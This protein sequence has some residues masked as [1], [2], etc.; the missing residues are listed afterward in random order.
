MAT[1]FRKELFDSIRPDLKDGKFP[2]VL[3]DGLDNVLDRAGVPRDDGTAVTASAATGAPTTF[4]KELTDLV[5][6]N[7]AT[8]SFS[9]E[10]V[11]AIDALLDRAGCPRDGTAPAGAPPK[12]EPVA[13]LAEVPPGRLDV[14]GL[15]AFLGLPRAGPFDDAAKSALLARLSNPKA[16]GL[17]DADIARAAADLGVS[18][19]HIKAVR[20]VEV[21]KSPFDDHGRPTI[22]YERHVFTRNTVPKGRFNAS[23]PAISGGPYGKGGY[24]LASAQYGKLADACALD[25]EAAF[26]GCSWGAFQVL[27]EHAIDLGYPSAVAM[28]FALCVSEAAHLDC[29]LR[30]LKRNSLVDEL[31]ACRAGD[32]ASCIPFVRRYNG[33]D[34]AT[35]Q[36]HK[37]LAA[38]LA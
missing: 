2:V 30:F 14:A 37:K 9:V 21:R 8:G 4:R 23:N 24:G 32:P 5:R 18:P 29:F 36:Y 10:L 26:R 7:L 31:R 22:L 34:F 16:P 15:R 19:N 25:P 17:T 13:P 12:P 11:K 1:L 33:Q 38:A 28:G 3:V 27:G 20:K 35:F 6:A